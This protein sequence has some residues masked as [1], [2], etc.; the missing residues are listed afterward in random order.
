VPGREAQNPSGRS[1]SSVAPA[2]MSTGYSLRRRPPV[3]RRDNGLF[4]PFP[5]GPAAALTMATGATPARPPWADDTHSTPTHTPPVSFSPPRIGN[6]VGKSYV[7]ISNRHG[8]KLRL[9]RF[10][11]ALMRE[12]DRFGRRVL[13]QAALQAAVVVIHPTIWTNFRDFQQR[14]HSDGTLTRTEFLT[15]RFQFPSSAASACCPP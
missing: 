5:P 15:T 11:R 13:S 6:A 7:A 4:M 8:W 9:Q 10:S 12:F 2:T 3:N 1:V 14:S